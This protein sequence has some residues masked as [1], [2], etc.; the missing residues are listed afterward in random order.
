M[1]TLLKSLKNP[2]QARAEYAAS[3]LARQCSVS[4]A[5]QDIVRELGGVQRLVQVILIL[6]L[7]FA[8]LLYHP[9]RSPCSKLIVVDANLVELRCPQYTG[10]INCPGRVSLNTVSA[11]MEGFIGELHTAGERVK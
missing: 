5:R 1:S 9:A 3:V 2:D 11:R 7:S 10:S 6:M 4:E 8:K